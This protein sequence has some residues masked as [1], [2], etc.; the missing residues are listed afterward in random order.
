[1]EAPQETRLVAGLSRDGARHRDADRAVC[2]PR[3]VVD[4]GG[5]VRALGGDHGD[6]RRDDR[7]GQQSAADP[8]QQ[9]RRQQIGVPRVGPG[10]GDAPADGCHDHERGEQ[11]D[12]GQAREQS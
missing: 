12:A 9:E 4:R 5:E 3:G 7:E 1:M 2:L 6:G 8:P 10:S 11:G